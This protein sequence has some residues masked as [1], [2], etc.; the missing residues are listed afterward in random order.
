[1]VPQNEN[2]LYNNIYSLSVNLYIH[3]NKQYILL[4]TLLVGYSYSNMLSLAHTLTS[5]LGLYNLSVL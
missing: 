1:M 3:H 2:H 4:G 5:S